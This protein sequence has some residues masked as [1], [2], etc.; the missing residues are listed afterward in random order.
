MAFLLALVRFLRIGI[1]LTFILVMLASGFGVALAN[2]SV[3][4]TPDSVEGKNVQAAVDFIEKY[5]DPKR[6]ANIKKWLKD[7]KIFWSPSQAENGDTSGSGNITISKQ[8]IRNDT[9]ART[10][11]TP[12]DPDKDFDAVAQLARSLVHEKVHAHQNDLWIMW[13]NLP[14]KT[15]HEYEAWT[16][17]LNEMDDWLKALYKEYRALPTT[18]FRERLKL[19]KH[20]LDIVIA[21]QTY[22][23]EFINAG[24]FGYTADC[25]KWKKLQ[26]D[27]DEWERIARQLI[28][29]IERMLLATSPASP[30]PSGPPGAVRSAQSALDGVMKTVA[31]TEH[32]SLGNGTPHVLRDDELAYEIIAPP[33]NAQTL[34]LVVH[35]DT[36]S[37]VS[38]VLPA[39][40]QVAP[41]DGDGPTYE[42]TRPASIDVGAHAS[43]TTTLSVRVAPAPQPRVRLLYTRS[44]PAAGSSTI[45]GLVMPS[46][47]RAGD[48]ISG[49][50]V[51]DVK[52][53]ADV[54]G[55]RAIALPLLGALLAGAVV[56][57]G[58]GFQP[59]NQPF[60]YTVPSNAQTVPVTVYGAGQPTP[61][62]N[63]P[64]P[65]RVGPP[66]ARIPDFTMPALCRPG[67]LHVIDGQL[68]GVADSMRIQ[69]A[70]RDA[71]ILAASPRA[72]Y[73]AVPE[74]VP[75][76]ATQV[77]L[78]D[79]GKTVTF[80]AAVAQVSLTADKLQLAK[81]ES[82][83]FHIS[84]S[85]LDAVP[86]VAWNGASL[87]DT[88]AH[89][90]LAALADAIRSSGSGQ[91]V[92]LISIM[93]KT[94]HSIA[95]EG[96]PG[97]VLVRQVRR[98]DVAAGPYL[99]SGTIHSLQSGAF[100][101]NASLV[102]L[103]APVRGTVTR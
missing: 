3:S 91:G 38:G 53:Y 68:S 36:T 67:E 29:N 100:S 59:A 7:G 58:H 41:R 103:L 20:M 76:G 66:D 22:L 80:R 25:P 92:V 88:I 81:N 71:V 99:F 16:V 31:D 102:P 27:L 47:I 85:G 18:K 60:T 33:G 39:G 11:S 5:G 87:P 97:G 19:L 57:F 8:I 54:P 23:A 84:I 42:L 62:L 61:I 83:T 77:T 12:F 43:A 89:D 56:Q 93:N 14:G 98:G 44:A 15:P 45:S 10:R 78:R 65:V 40:T 2:D 21:K 30:G 4:V 34:R 6:A 1:G 13:S 86:A 32:A 26:K 37:N 35:N 55:L 82:T 70:G 101:V 50:V 51:P 17:T 46:Y 63:E 74:D 64:I 94:P 52:K 48:T 69:V 72:V 9:N 24:C 96:A 49:I 95:I 28:A 90:Q 79:A 73:F 75:A